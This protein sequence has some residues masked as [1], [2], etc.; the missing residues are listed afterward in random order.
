MNPYITPLGV[1]PVPGFSNARGDQL[2]GACI[3]DA[4]AAAGVPPGSPIRQQLAACGLLATF[5]AGTTPHQLPYS[6]PTRY[7]HTNPAPTLY[8][9]PDR[10]G[11]TLELVRP[12]PELVGVVI[13]RPAGSADPADEFRAFVEDLEPVT[14]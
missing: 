6:W 5:E 14:P 11:E 7:A 2:D 10:P 9:D 1:R 12:V 4:A 3:A 8:A 13:V